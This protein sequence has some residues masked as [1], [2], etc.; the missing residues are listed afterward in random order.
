MAQPV[1][2]AQRRA[3]EWLREHGGDGCFTRHGIALAQ[4]E[5]APYERITWDHLRNA[6]LIEY[7]GGAEGYGRLRIVEPPPA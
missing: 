2:R 6:G 7:Y 3:L 1:T 5:L 4:G